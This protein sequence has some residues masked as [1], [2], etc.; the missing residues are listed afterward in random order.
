MKEVRAIAVNLDSCVGC[1]ACEIACKQENNVPEGERW[2]RKIP[3]GPHE[4]DGKMRM[5]FLSLNT[6]DCNFCQHR[7]DEGNLPRCV[8]NCPT[9]AL[10][11]Y[12]NSLELLSALSNG[13]RMQICKLEAP[14][15]AFQ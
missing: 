14:H 7:L 15:R 2:T 3:V 13:K 1:Y 12:P 8:D 11:Y 4:I 5:D 6:E 9:E 10:K